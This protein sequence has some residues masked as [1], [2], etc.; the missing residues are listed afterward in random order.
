[1]ILSK[2]SKESSKLV[3]QGLC[4]RFLILHILSLYNHFTSYPLSVKPKQADRLIKAI[5][6]RLQGYKYSEIATML[7]IKE[8]SVKKDFQTLKE[9]WKEFNK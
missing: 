6:L 2:N 9:L 4:V 8:T 5:E 7:D 1:M 3:Q